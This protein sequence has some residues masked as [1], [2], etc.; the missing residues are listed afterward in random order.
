M[1][2][3]EGD[4]EEPYNWQDSRLST[5]N[6]NKMTGWIWNIMYVELYVK[7]QHQNVTKEQ[8]EPFWP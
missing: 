5:S 4:Q 3:A 8:E 6:T 1:A 2:R 7:D